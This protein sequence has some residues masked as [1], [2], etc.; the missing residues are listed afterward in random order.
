MGSNLPNNHSYEL[1]LY[2]EEPNLLVFRDL[3]THTMIFIGLVT[4]MFSGAYIQILYNDAANAFAFF[5][6][7]ALLAGIL[8]CLMMLGHVLGKDERLTINALDRMVEYHY[9]KFGKSYGWRKS[10]SDFKCIQ[11]MID[12]DDDNDKWWYFYLV[13]HDGKR[14]MLDCKSPYLGRIKAKDK[15]K[16]H[17]FA[18]KL[19]NAMGIELNIQ[20][21]AIISSATLLRIDQIY[22][23]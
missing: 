10:F 2:K 4:L 12:F 5:P 20:D 3:R 21:K 18:R 23:L 16:A 17:A 15:D 9:Q 1:A 11:M 7:Y 22:D 8:I 19:T 14:I 6:G 13:A